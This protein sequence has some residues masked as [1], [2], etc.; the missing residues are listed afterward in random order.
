MRRIVIGFLAV[1]S[2]LVLAP[3]T[4][5]ACLRCRQTPCVLPQAACAPAFQTVTEMVPYTVM[6]A[7]TR[8]DFREESRTVM[9]REPETTWEERQRV[10]CKPVIETTTV[11][12]VV[13]VCRPVVETDYVSRNVTVCRPVSTT[14]QVTEY[15]M[16]PSTQ[17]VTVPVAAGGKCGRC[18]H[19]RPSCGCQTVARTCYTPVP[20]VRDVVETRMVRE[21]ET[22]QVPVTRCS[23]VR[24]QQVIDVPVYHTRLVRETVTERIP[25]VTIRCVPKTITRQ[26]PFP[27]C[28][29]VAETRYRPVTRVVPVA[30]ASAPTYQA[31]PTAQSASAQH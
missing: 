3:V 8:I 27:V 7:Q 29:T 30:P 18:G 24:E 4:A 11:Q 19:A 13:N 15:C 12:R 21:V 25:H 1:V 9:V 5:S 6:R 20:V 2:A 16:Q 10:V 28:E 14:R 17:Y 31:A 22:R 23:I 26:V